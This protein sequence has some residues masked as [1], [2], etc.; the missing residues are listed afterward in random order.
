MKKTDSSAVVH[1]VKGPEKRWSGEETAHD[2]LAKNKD[3]THWFK[4]SRAEASAGKGAF[5]HL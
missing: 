4:N 5:S 1:S 2:T 3:L